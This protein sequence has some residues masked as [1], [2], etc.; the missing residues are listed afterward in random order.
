M[1]F[2]LNGGLGGVDGSIVLE[3]IVIAATLIPSVSIPP[4]LLHGAAM[5]REENRTVLL[6]SP[7]FYVQTEGDL[8]ICT[9]PVHV[10]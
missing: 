3:P 1:L 4:T 9:L 5:R 6:S 8:C 10:V 2:R 7:P